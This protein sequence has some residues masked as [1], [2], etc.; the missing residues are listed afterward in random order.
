[1][2]MKETRDSLDPKNTLSEHFDHDDYRVS[3]HCFCFDFELNEMHV[4]V[5][6]FFQIIHTFNSK[7]DIDNFHCSSDNSFGLES[8]STARFELTQRKTGLFHGFLDACA[9]R[10]DFKTTGGF[11]NLRSKPPKVRAFLAIPPKYCFNF[12]RYEISSFQAC[13]LL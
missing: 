6:C 3:H 8:C 11:T 9:K 4:G 13:F 2:L 7:E 10:G 12:D 5:V 1:M